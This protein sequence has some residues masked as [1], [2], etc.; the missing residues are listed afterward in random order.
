LFGGFFDTSKSFVL[1]NG[2]EGVRG[3][4]KVQ[5]KHPNTQLLVVGHTDTAGRPAYNDPLSRERAAAMAAY[6]TGAVED[7]YTWYGHDVA[8]EKRWGNREDLAMIDA[9]PDADGRQG[10]ENPVHWFQRTR[11]LKVD[12]I[13]GQETRHA[14]IKEYMALEG[15]SLPD[16]V[17]VTTH[18]CGENFPAE[19]TG[20]G[21]IDQENR[22]VEIFLFD[23]KLGI[24]PKP[25][26]KNSAPASTA[27]PEWGKRAGAPIDF[28][29]EA[30]A[31]A[32]AIEWPEDV[33]SELPDDVAVVL[34][35]EGLDP[36]KH[37]L[38][39]A[40][41]DDGVI[42]VSFDDLDPSHLVTLTAK[43]G[44]RELV[45]FRDHRVGDLDDPTVWEHTLDEL[46]AD[47]DCPDDGLVVT[48]SLPDDAEADLTTK[49]EPRA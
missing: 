20:D 22:R 44:S 46:I 11:G 48:G 35:G 47:D 30:D 2:I 21:V 27:Y 18:G 7:W 43:H 36:Q 24:Q 8:S 29:T 13:A 12:D 28:F 1:P 4:V 5:A 41:R 45:L 10:G 34:T 15:T 26:G 49:P 38:A 14:L 40:N 6:L 19:D 39:A 3:L 9:L 16:G 17:H 25:P 32:L 37:L 33:V 31:V 23:A 42:R